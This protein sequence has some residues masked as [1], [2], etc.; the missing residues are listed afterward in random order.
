MI[1]TGPV[2]WAHF[3][4]LDAAGCSDEILNQMKIF[5]NKS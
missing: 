2:G 3:R 1:Q 5:F 4:E